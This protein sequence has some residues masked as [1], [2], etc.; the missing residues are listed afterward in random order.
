MNFDGA[1]CS[2]PRQHAPTVQATW[3]R[4]SGH[5]FYHGPRGSDARAHH[6]PFSDVQIR[7]AERFPRSR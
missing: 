5:A 6:A 4:V 3:Y 2:I 1:A 7:S